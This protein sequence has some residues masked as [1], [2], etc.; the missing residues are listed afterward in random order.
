MNDEVPR[1]KTEE[2][3]KLSIKETVLAHG[4]R[5]LL[6]SDILQVFHAELYLKKTK[7]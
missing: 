1:R 6:L 5:K 2:G 4:N 7:I 3:A